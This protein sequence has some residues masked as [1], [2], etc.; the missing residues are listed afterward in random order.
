MEVDRNQPYRQDLLTPDLPASTIAPRMGIVPMAEV[1]GA[2]AGRDEEGTTRK[3][4]AK[5]GGA[6][7]LEGG[8]SIFELLGR[9][10]A[11]MRPL[12]EIQRRV[13]GR[14]GGASYSESTI[15]RLVSGYGR[16][17]STLG[18]LG[19]LRLSPALHEACTRLAR[20]ARSAKMLEDAG[21]V[22]H[23]STPFESVDCC[24]GDAEV[25]HGFLS[26]YYREKWRDLRRDIESRIAEYEIDTEAKATFDEA[27]IAHEA[28][29]Y[30]CVCR[31]LIP[32]IERVARKE[33]HDD[34]MDRIT[35]Q[36]RLQELAG[37]LPLRSVAGPRGLYNLNL[38]R[39]LSN[40]LYAHVTTDED[41]I[42]F[43]RDPVPNR[44]AA[45]HGLVAYSSMQS[46]LNAIF[47]ADY[48]FFVITVQKRSASLQP[49]G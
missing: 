25:L 31:V 17:A 46:S 11:A 47:L 19:G 21:W 10:N 7:E 22:A 15:G 44:H 35:N 8:P 32:E 42:R 37:K 14:F 5:G 26:R 16:F 20:H 9:L 29:L 28:G 49:S 40:H 30:R 27:L 38:Y 13:S 24:D 23:F 3:S 18:V 12:M 45:V 34:R 6:S 4:S 36:E 43:A 33:L 2:S 1:A 41:R 48:I 39:R